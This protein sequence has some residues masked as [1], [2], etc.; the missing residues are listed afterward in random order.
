MDSTSEA[1]NSDSEEDEVQDDAQPKCFLKLDDWIKFSFEPG[2]SSL[3]VQL[4]LKWHSLFMRRMRTPTKLWSQYDESTVRTIVGV[5]TNE[6]QALGLQQP[7]GIGQRPR[8][9]CNETTV[10]SGGFKDTPVCN[11][12]VPSN[13][14]SKKDECSMLKIS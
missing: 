11:F 9:M 3:V 10:L 2:V 12:D 5:L 14:E 1:W 6:E 4:R 13:Q 8:P 7:S